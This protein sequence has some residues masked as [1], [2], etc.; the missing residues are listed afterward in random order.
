MPLWRALTVYRLAAWAYATLLVARNFPQYAH[1]LAGWAVLAVM[2]GWSVATG[3]AYARPRWR[4]WP[5]LVADL[6]VTAACLMASPWVF[7]PGGQ[8][9]R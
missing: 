2:A 6:L 1:P 7:G 5:L 8:R 3:Y 4:G 9:T